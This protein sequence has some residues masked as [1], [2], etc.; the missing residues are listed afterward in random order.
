MEIWKILL[1][2]ISNSE[3][4]IIMQWFQANVSTV[5][6]VL[7]V[8]LLLTVCTTACSS[9]SPSNERKLTWAVSCFGNC[10]LLVMTY[11]N[12]PEVHQ[13][14]VIAAPTHSSKQC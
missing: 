14:Y 2:S 10:H 1:I 6:D 4:Q 12:T 7:S 9:K 3:E 8:T 5:F 11:F 13:S